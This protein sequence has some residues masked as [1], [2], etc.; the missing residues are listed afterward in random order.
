M[1]VF[2]KTKYNKF[3]NIPSFVDWKYLNQFHSDYSLW[4]IESINQTISILVL[5]NL[6]SELDF[7]LSEQVSTLK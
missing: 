3:R 2:E 6:F 1:Y 4:L 7:K 5:Q